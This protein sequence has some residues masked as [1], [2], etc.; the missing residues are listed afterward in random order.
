MAIK[1]NQRA[2][3]HARSLIERRRV[4]LDERDDWRAHRPTARQRNLYIRA[5]GIRSY[6]T[7]FLAIDD[8]APEGTKARHKFPYGDFQ[9]VHRCAVLSAERRA[10]Q[11]RYSDVEAAAAD[12]HRMLDELTWSKAM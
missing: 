2:L 11:Y 10:G 4:V 6:G 12:L 8:Q 1:L 9:N 7:W 5:N 3:Q